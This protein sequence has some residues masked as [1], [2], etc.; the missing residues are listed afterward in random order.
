MTK[1]ECKFFLPWEG[2][3]SDS[4]YKGQVNTP[5]EAAD[6]LYMQAVRDW[7]YDDQGI[8]LQQ[9]GFIWG[10]Q[11]TTIQDI[12]SLTKHQQVR[13]TKDKNVLL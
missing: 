7:L 5:H 11:R 9:N 2:R 12:K 1:S 8:H 4:P 6:T 10:Q 13:R 3:L